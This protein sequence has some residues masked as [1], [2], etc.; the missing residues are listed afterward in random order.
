MD[1]E[2]DSE[3]EWEEEPEDGEQLSVRVPPAT[4]S[5]PA[6]ACCSQ[7]ASEHKIS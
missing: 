3:D 5:V 2:V 6:F 4:H 7:Q 1:Y